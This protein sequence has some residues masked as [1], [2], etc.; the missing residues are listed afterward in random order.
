M[1]FDFATIPAK[2]RYKLWLS[3]VVPRPI[4][5]IVSQ[6]SGQLN[7][8]LFSFFN[9][10]AA[11]PPVVEIGIGSHDHARPKDTLLRP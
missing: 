7:A 3:T 11:D 9:A 8:A 6:D 10:F 1:L 5:W 2:E 4:A